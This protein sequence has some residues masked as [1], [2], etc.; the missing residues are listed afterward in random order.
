MGQLVEATYLL[1]GDE[2]LA[3]LAAWLDGR[4]PPRGRIG[5][6]LDRGADSYW[7]RNSAPFDAIGRWLTGPYFTDTEALW[8]NRLA[9]ANG[10][11]DVAVAYLTAHAAAYDHRMRHLKERLNS[12]LAAE[13]LTGN[14]RAGWL[15]ARAYAAAILPDGIPLPVR[16]LPDLEEAFL[17]AESPAVRF[18]VLEELVAVWASIG[19][20]DRVREAI[21]GF[22]QQGLGETELSALA[23]WQQQAD[24][25]AVYYADD[26]L[27]QRT[28]QRASH[29]TSLEV[30]LKRAETNGNQA[31]ASQLHSLLSQ[32]PE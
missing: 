26:E 30:R 8:G 29:R 24:A 13:D 32:L 9:R 7:E 21:Q 14:R 27:R 3:L 6:M 23:A 19:E 12:T 4:S 17:A 25:L 31:E 20:T 15:V 22:G 18:W 2:H 28:A 5:R 10:E 11:C 1:P 16:G